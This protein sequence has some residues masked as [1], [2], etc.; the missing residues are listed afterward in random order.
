M[1]R[2]RPFLALFLAFCALLAPQAGTAQEFPKLTGRVVDAAGIIPDAEEARLTQKLEV[3][4]RQSR[5]QLVVAT[6]PDLQ[7]YDISDYGY[8]LGRAWGIGQKDDD[9]GALLIV[10]PNERKVRIEVGYGLEPV[11]T[12]GMSF[13]IINKA[14]V[15]RFKEDDMAGGIEAGVDAIVQQLTLPPEEAQ[16]IAAQADQQRERGGGIPLGVI[17]FILIIVFF[18]VM[19]MINEARGGGRRRR[20]GAGP[21]VWIP[22]GFGGGGGGGF[23]GGGGGFGGGGFSGGGGSFGGGGSSGSW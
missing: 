13:L 6:I 7:G 21:I 11:L 2:F 19:P 3:L 17:V 4:E 20:Y 22:G 8:Q 15:P 16:K 10:A 23:G 9:N 14:I 5:R 18:V 12:D 1:T